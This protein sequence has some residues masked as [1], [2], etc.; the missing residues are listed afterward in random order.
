[1]SKYR[2]L[3]DIGTVMTLQTPPINPKHIPRDP[4]ER[5]QWVIGQL[6]QRGTSCRKLSLDAGY[7]ASYA[8]QCLYVALQ[9]AEHLIATA[10]GTTEAVLFPERHDENGIRL[11]RRNPRHKSNHSTQGRN[12]QT[13]GAA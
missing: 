12:G 1:M 5:A 6:K 7:N 9:P 2:W 3:I 4:Y 8:V 10:L 13:R 11:R